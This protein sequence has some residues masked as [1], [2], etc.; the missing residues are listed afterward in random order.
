KVVSQRSG[1]WPFQLGKSP[2]LERRAEIDGEHPGA[3]S[4]NGRPSIV[5][6]PGHDTPLPVLQS[7]LRPPSSSARLF[8]AAAHRRLRNVVRAFRFLSLTRSAPDMTHAT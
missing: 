3:A 2:K 7:N 8:A 4:E 6:A 5:S 1:S